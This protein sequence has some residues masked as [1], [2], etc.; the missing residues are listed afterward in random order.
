MVTITYGEKKSIQV[1]PGITYQEAARLVQSEFEHE[2][3]LVR[4]DNKLKELHKQIKG[5]ET[6]HFITTAERAGML[7]Y[8]RSALMLLSKALHMVAGPALEMVWV[9]FS[10]INGYYVELRGVDQQQPV[11]VD[12]VE[13]GG[14]RHEALRAVDGAE[15]G[16]VAGNRVAQ[17]FAVHEEI[18]PRVLRAVE[19]EDVVLELR[20]IAALFGAGGERRGE[21]QEREQ[22]E[23]EKSSKAFHKVSSRKIPIFVCTAGFRRRRFSF[24]L[25]SIKRRMSKPRRVHWRAGGNAG[26]FRRPRDQNVAKSALSEYNTLMGRVKTAAREN[27]SNGS[28]G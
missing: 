5:S 14:C 16:D 9:E 27:N 25:Y 23:R 13:R 6:V 2:I 4:T 21:Q 7:T 1:P 22:G 15:L 3:V 26:K 11:P 28:K 8:E 24:K 19:M 17:L 10:V 18:G 12:M 20:G